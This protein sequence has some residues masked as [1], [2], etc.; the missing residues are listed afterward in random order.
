MQRQPLRQ[1]KANRSLSTLLVISA[2]LIF[3][4]LGKRG[5]TTV[6]PRVNRNRSSEPHAPKC[7]K[8]PLQQPPIPWVR[9]TTH[10]RVILTAESRP[11]VTIKATEKFPIHYQNRSRLAVTKERP[12]TGMTPIWSTCN[13]QPQ[14]TLYSHKR[15]SEE[16]LT[17]V[18]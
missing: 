6:P 11:R 12:S 18:F 15:R 2:R 7:N 16:F 8:P 14:T 3:F 4:S 9:I 10:Q 5:G 1:S 13:S 17:F